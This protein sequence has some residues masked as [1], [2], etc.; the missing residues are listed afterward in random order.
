MLQWSVLWDLF[1]TEKSSTVQLKLCIQWIQWQ[2]ISQASLANRWLSWSQCPL[3][4]SLTIYNFRQPWATAFLIHA[5]RATACVIRVI[6]SSSN[7]EIKQTP[8]L[9]FTDWQ[10][11]CLQKWILPSVLTGVGRSRAAGRIDG[12]AKLPESAAQRA[13]SISASHTCRVV[14]GASLSNSKQKSISSRYIYHLP[15]E[16]RDQSIVN[17]HICKRGSLVGR[18]WAHQDSGGEWYHSKRSTGDVWFARGV[19]SAHCTSDRHASWGLIKKYWVVARRRTVL[20]FDPPTCF[21][22]RGHRPLWP[23]HNTKR[24]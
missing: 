8:C 16:W 15:E 18:R 9:M 14:A 23:A 12:R 10:R 3:S 22:S 24:K 2:L 5:L 11:R 7:R 6:S 17:L 19:G 21:A 4:K 20:E 1:L 13:A